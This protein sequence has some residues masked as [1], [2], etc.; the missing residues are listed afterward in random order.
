MFIN[1]NVLQIE[2]WNV[3]KYD[4]DDTNQIMLTH[5]GV[6]SFQR[7]KQWH[8]LSGMECITLKITKK[9]RE[10]C[11]Y[12]IQKGIN[13]YTILDTHTCKWKEHIF[14]QRNHC[15]KAVGHTHLMEHN[16]YNIQYTYRW[17]NCKV[18]LKQKHQIHKEYTHTHT[19]HRYG[20]WFVCTVLRNKWTMK[21]VL[22]LW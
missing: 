20:I 14:N 9:K 6:Y 7:P 3:C 1:W 2:C 10:I 16:T 5:I 21:S 22:S 19:N 15:L 4:N 17:E 12:V 18:A 11:L 8:S 13:T